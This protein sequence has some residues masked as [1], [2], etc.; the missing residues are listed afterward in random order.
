MS[1]K[2]YA[3]HEIPCDQSGYDFIREDDFANLQSE[4]DALAAE[5]EGLRAIRAAAEAVTKAFRVL[6]ESTAF[7]RSESNA[8]HNCEQTMV[9][10]DAAIEAA[11][12][13]GG[14]GHE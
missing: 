14:E 5:V 6:G 9:A 2:R 12:T 1:I 8:R 4:R 3:K 7:T 13:T 11:S 10:L